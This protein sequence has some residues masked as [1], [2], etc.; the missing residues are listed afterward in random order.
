MARPGRRQ[1]GARRTTPRRDRRVRHDGDLV[2]VLARTAREVEAAAARGRVTPSVRTRFQA[3]ALL[4]REE[5]ARVQA[6]PGSDGSR[7]EQL[8]RLDGVATVLATTAVRDAGLLALLGE[9]AVV[10][11]AARSLRREI[12][13]D[14]GVE[15]APEEP[16]PA[17]AE[18][19]PAGPDRRVVPQSVVSRQL[20]NPFLA[21]D[22]SAL[23]Q[24]PARPRRLAGW[25]LL[26]PL[27]TSFERA[28]AGAPACMDLP[29]PTSR[30]TPAGLELMPHQGQ[31]VAAAA[32]GH[33]TFL[34]ADEPGLG[35]TA[36]AL[37]AAEAAGAHPLLVVVPNVVKTNW[38]REAA[39]WTPHRR[40]TVVQGDGETVDGFADVVV[41]NYEV[42]DRHVGW[43]GDFGFRGI[44]VDEA[45]FI[46]NKGSQR[47]RHVLELS[48]RLRSL[49]RTPLLMALTG[50]PLIN[51][52]DD[53]RAIWQFLGWIDDDAPLGELLDALED[54]GLT[55]ADRGFSAAARQCVID[56]GIVRRRKA[57]VAADIPARRIADLPVELDGPVGRSIR[58]AERD[59]VR[60]M[61]AQ[62]ETALA[63]RSSGTAAGEVDAELVRRVARS[64]LK[65]AATG[66]G[67]NVF[68]T[69]RR[70]GRAKAG[71]AADY[72]A[73]LARSA[74]KV[75]FFAKHVD[76]MDAAEEALARQGVR[77]ASI[78]GDQTPRARQASVDA[79]TTDPEVAVA[80]CSL[81]AAGVGLNLQVASN[82]VL[83]ELSWTDAEQT[84]AIDRSHRIG[85]TEPV[86]AWRIIAAQTIDARVAELVDSKA[87]LAARALDGS[88]EPAGAPNDV[89]VE[90]LVALLTDALR[91]AA[92]PGDLA[93]V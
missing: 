61:V 62:Y 1:T 7:A 85:Q 20:A 63:A 32:G 9:D 12:L 57:D 56:L 71:L 49:G 34:L 37:L 21:P 54:T 17:P 46:K 64:E 14:L 89:Q 43:L 2:A 23:P 81:T 27:F 83:A 55:P 25:E 30:F 76:V 35:K 58:A 74:G 72:A 44:V 78:R 79:F 36:Q 65:D 68:A 93:A 18:A 86:T 5:R 66:T 13:R 4:L 31:V 29:V 51:D 87:G 52:V 16:A 10:T 90:V 82:V 50:T 70:I 39:R 28:G 19:V 22:F 67:E 75:V 84:Q 40:A 41:V 80:V 53:F 6:A 59:L 15:P 11:D 3:V 88:D 73:Q 33:R 91:E 47:S 69:M 26:G 92:G 77:Y 24:R 45:H 60:R 48:A 42:L 8:K 38:A